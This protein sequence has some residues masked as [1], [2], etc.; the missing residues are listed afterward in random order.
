MAAASTV[1]LPIAVVDAFASAAFRGNPAA[2][3][4][5]GRGAFLP[6]AVLQAIAKENNLAETAFVRLSSREDEA[7]RFHI[8]FFTPEVEINLCGHA[9]LATAKVLFAPGGAADGER[10]LR[11]D[12]L[13]GALTVTRGDEAG[14]TAGAARAAGDESWLTLDF[15][16]WMPEA[17]APSA[18][19][20]ALFAALGIAAEDVLWSGRNRDL[21]VVLKSPAAVA[22]VR[23]D[24]RAL[25]Q[26]P[27]ATVVIV[28]AEGDGEH[29]LPAAA[30][31]A[32]AVAAAAAAAA[33]AGAGAASGAP[34]FVCRAFCPNC[35]AVPEDPVCG[36]AH[37][38]L[39]PVFAQ[40]LGRTRL[41][42]HQLS[43]RGGELRC[44]LVG[45][46]VR[47]A[48]TAVVYLR[49]TI[50]VPAAL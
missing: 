24:V 6:D 13:G 49:G 1:S 31:A 15:P 30:A 47:I 43:A 10:E 16:A 14:G 35:P 36:S 5:F 46:R 38:S 32:A 37:C 23:L 42:S 17:L 29:H 2:V 26:V 40:R 41:V 21:V 4:D 28:A 22:A 11:L 44:A 33:G 7:R 50:E 48:G 45:D 3:V 27:G 20:P 18:L 39:I 34:D 9:T 12:C 25:D 19:P 8:R